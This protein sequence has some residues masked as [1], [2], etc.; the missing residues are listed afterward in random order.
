[1]AYT[2]TIADPIRY[3]FAVGRVRVLETRLLNRSHFERLLD[4]PSFAEQRRILSETVYGGYLEDAVTAEDVEVALDR[5]LLDVYQDFLETANL[6]GPMVHFF[7]VQHDFE[8]LRGILKAETVGIPAA[9]LLND[10]GS[11]PAADFLTDDLP[12][13][14]RP[15][16]RRV[17]D[18]IGEIDDPARADLVDPAVD[19]EMYRELT[20]LAQDSPSVH[21]RDIARLGA[22]L[23]N[24]KAF[25]RTR[26]RNM[27]AAEAARFFV[28]GGEIPVDRFVALYRMPLEDAAVQLVALPLLRGTDPVALA[29]P[30]RIDV[31]ADRILA[32][33][34]RGALMVAIGPEPVIGY[35]YARRAEVTTLRMLLI[36]KL[37]G[38]GTDMLRSRLRDVA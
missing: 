33:R 3:G 17:R 28:P 18:A 19:A 29:D 20:E 21:I 31:I 2:R 27:P 25:L 8:N 12:A 9:E 7:R 4:A 36:G 6:P 30:G 23:A 35:V 26:A 13:W 34:L 22:D 11:V 32:R 37:A 15:I 14:L 1:M 5:A 10:L 16:E 38:V 24:V